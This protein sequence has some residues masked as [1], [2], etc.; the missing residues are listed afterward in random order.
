MRTTKHFDYIVNRIASA[1]INADSLASGIGH[2]GIE[3]EIREIAAK[4][5]IEPFLT[6]SYQCGTGKVIDS[7]QGLSDQLDLIIY[8]RKVAPPI[9]VGRDL[10]LYPV[11]CVRYVFEVKSTLSSREIRD[12]NKKFRSVSNLLS[13]PRR[14]IDGSVKGGA[15]PATVLLA[16][17]SD[18]T[19][20]EIDRYKRHTQ[21]ESPPCTV[22]CVLGKGY[23]YYDFASRDWY[24]LEANSD[25]PPFVE[26]GMFI[27]GLMNTLSSEETAIRPFNPGIYINV[28]DVILS[29]LKKSGQ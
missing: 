19:S 4:E 1:K 12:A 8:H 13:F 10:G 2:H 11:E 17:N 25:F 18:I 21:D 23:W 16:F 7:F 9:L 22:L 14:E 6:Q 27:T 28:D 26:F 15:L 24:G 5:C 3:G 29:A 20:S